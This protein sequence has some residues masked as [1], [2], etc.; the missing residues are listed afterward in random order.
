MIK[1][2]LLKSKKRRNKKNVL[3]KVTPFLVNHILFHCEMNTK[4]T[5][6]QLIIH[7]YFIFSIHFSPFT[8]TNMK[9]SNECEFVFTPNYRYRDKACFLQIT[10]H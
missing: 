9:E 10:T 6:K 3:I 2:L 8:V 1:V 4:V 5:T 7:F